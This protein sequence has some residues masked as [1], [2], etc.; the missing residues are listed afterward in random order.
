MIGYR[1]IVEIFNVVQYNLRDS[2]KIS[3]IRYK[4]NRYKNSA[5]LYLIGPL[6]DS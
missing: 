3:G 4:T 5:M 2:H 1:N 6:N